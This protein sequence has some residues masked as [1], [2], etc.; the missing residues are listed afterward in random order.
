MLLNWLKIT[1]KLLLVKFISKI[2]TI[3]KI[4]LTSVNPVI[5]FYK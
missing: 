3:F 4:N 2:L 1:A 5:C